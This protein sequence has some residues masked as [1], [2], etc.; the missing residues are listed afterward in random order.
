[1][2]STW[3]LTLG[4]QAEMVY[5][6]VAEKAKTL[7]RVSTVVPLRTWENFPAAYIV[8]PH[9]VICRTCSTEPSVPLVASCGVA[10]GTLDTRAE[11]GPASRPRVSAPTASVTPASL[12]LHSACFVLVDAIL[13]VPIGSPAGSDP[14]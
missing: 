2:V 12:P 10:A 7:L 14:G 11:A 3:P 5:G 8:P 1:M 9:C 6:L 4:F 13:A